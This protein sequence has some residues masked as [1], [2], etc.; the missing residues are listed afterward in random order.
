MQ[1]KTIALTLLAS[2]IAAPAFAQQVFPA[3]L[4]GHAVQP[5]ATFIAA[6]QDAPADLQA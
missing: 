4:A 5:A 1:K 2:A 3:T 6:P